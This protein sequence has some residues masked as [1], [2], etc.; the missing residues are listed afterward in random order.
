VIMQG[1]VPGRLAAQFAHWQIGR[2]SPLP[3]PDEE[4]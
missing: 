3:S 1:R 2:D 4:E